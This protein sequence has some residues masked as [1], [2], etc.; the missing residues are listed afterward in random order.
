VGLKQIEP[1]VGVEEL[2]V[3]LFGGR[4]SG[5]RGRAK[6]GGFGEGQTGENVD[7]AADRVVNREGDV[8][9]WINGVGDVVDRVV[10]HFGD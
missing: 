9:V 6:I 1:G 2:G 8:A 7:R 5:G 4:G 10:A 3:G